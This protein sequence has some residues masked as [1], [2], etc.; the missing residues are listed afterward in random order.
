MESYEVLRETMSEV[1]IKAVAA[2][3][4]LSTSLL[5][6]WCQKPPSDE[7]IDESGARNP[8]DRI[9]QIR[10]ITGRPELIEW[11]CSQSNGFFVPNHPAVEAGQMDLDVISNTQRMIK[12]FS[13][14]LKEVSRALSDDRG[15]DLDE[16]KRIRREWDDLKSRAESFV[17]ACEHGVF[18]SEK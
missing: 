16:A 6:K 1:G 14:V 9:I 5:Y 4:G 18:E 3:L 17:S 7:D 15:I 8:L 12:D 11:L 10:Q 2:E 13:D